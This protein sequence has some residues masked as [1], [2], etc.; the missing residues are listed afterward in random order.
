MAQI[1]SLAD[2][3]RDLRM[4]LPRAQAAGPP[5]SLLAEKTE[6]LN[7]A[8]RQVSDITLER[9]LL[10]VDLTA[11]KQAVECLNDALAD[12]QRG[13]A[14]ALEEAESIRRSALTMTKWAK[15]ANEREAGYK[16]DIARL[17]TEIATLRAQ[18]AAVAMG[19]G[20][21]GKVANAPEPTGEPSAITR[22]FG[23]YVRALAANVMLT[24][25]EIAKRINKDLAIE[26]MNAM[27]VCSIKRE[28][29]IGGAG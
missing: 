21:V 16:A 27:V 18:P 8:L 25:T 19:G 9:D 24:D 22:E 23:Q 3:A 5:Q 15:E 13:E 14:R 17:K 2:V 29:G 6:A 10:A 26:R 12:A 4:A 28:L 1:T 7:A 11:E 20:T